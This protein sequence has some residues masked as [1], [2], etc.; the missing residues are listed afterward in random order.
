[1]EVLVEQEA[2]RQL[3]AVNDDRPLELSEVVSY[4]LNRLPTLYAS[5]K[6]GL[7]FQLQRGH[8]DYGSQIF[9]VVQ[10]A[11]AA[12]SQHPQTTT[13]IRPEDRAEWAEVIGGATR[14]AK[15]RKLSSKWQPIARS[16]IPG[17]AVRPTLAARYRAFP[18]NH[19]APCAATVAELEV[20][21]PPQARLLP[22]P[23]EVDAKA[24]QRLPVAA[25]DEIPTLLDAN[26]GMEFFAPTA[27]QPEIVPSIEIAQPSISPSEGEIT[28][29]FYASEQAP[30][31]DSLLQWIEETDEEWWDGVFSQ[32]KSA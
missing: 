30:A 6:Q 1:M 5:T 28:N 20:A 8:M 18:R 31:I 21:T 12:V 26:E 29:L 22:S 27:E 11:I 13:P 16:P 4:A 9:Q 15:Q 17:V 2:R 19:S 3:G 24:V 7:Q 10:S 23:L 25:S 32:S 14:V